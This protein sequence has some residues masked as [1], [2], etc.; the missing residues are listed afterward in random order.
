MTDWGNHEK[1]RD[2]VF[3]EWF[4]WSGETLPGERSNVRYR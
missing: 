2:A 4:L 1:V 3:K